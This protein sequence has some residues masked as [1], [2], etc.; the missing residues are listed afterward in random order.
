MSALV[1]QQLHFSVAPIVHAAFKCAP[2]ADDLT[3]FTGVS[4]GE[5]N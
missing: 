3:A 4:S 5:T 2:D 1:E